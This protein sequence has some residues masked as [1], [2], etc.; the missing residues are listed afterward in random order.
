VTAI[1]VADLVGDIPPETITV[2]TFGAS[3]INAYGEAEAT[4]VDT[5]LDAVVHPTGRRA[6][7]R[8][9]LDRKRETISVYATT[10][11]GASDTV[12]PPRVQYATRW[13]EVVAHGDYGELGGLYLIHAALL[14]AAAA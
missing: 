10:A 3:T 1:P 5:S 9:G 7:E 12:R 8:M 13:Y 6:L 14:D 2:R 4:Y 11:L